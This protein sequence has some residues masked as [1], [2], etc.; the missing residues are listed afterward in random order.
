MRGA[1]EQ[2]IVE[3]RQLALRA[4][5]A[6]VIDAGGGGARISASV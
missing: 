5:A 2:Q 4:A 6:D 3:M 1:E